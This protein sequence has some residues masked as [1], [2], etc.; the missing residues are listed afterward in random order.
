MNAS[1]RTDDELL[2]A[3]AENHDAL[4]FEELYTRHGG[5]VF[6]MCR[7]ILR[8]HEDAEDAAAACFLVLHRKAHSVRS[9]KLLAWLH[10]CAVQTA[11]RVYNTAKRRMERE[12]EAGTMEFTA[13]DASDGQWER[14][15]PDIEREIAA[16]S[17]VLREVLIMHFYQGLTRTEMAGRLQCAEGTIGSR[18]ANAMKTLRKRLTRAGADTTE[19]AISAGLMS[20]A[21]VVAMPSGLVMKL[22][23]ISQG[24][25]IGE[26]V[27]AMAEDTMRALMLAKMKLAAGIA[28]AVVCGVAVPAITISMALSKPHAVAGAVVPTSASAGKQVESVPI[29]KFHRRWTFDA[30]T[31]A[32]DFTLIQG[33]WHWERGADGEGCMVQDSKDGD[34]VFVL[35]CRVPR[36]PFVLTCVGRISSN[37]S[38]GASWIDGDKVL[39]YKRWKNRDPEP[40]VKRSLHTDR[41]FFIGRHIFSVSSAGDDVRGIAENQLEYPSDQIVVQ[42][43]DKPLR[44]LELRELEPEEVAKYQELLDKKL[45]E[46]K[47]KEV[48]FAD[49]PGE[50]VK[51]PTGAGRAEEKK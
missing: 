16:L 3:Y 7:R 8:I 50:K 6:S 35:P 22:A 43:I 31:L 38:L 46:L 21:L 51:I 12:Q 15:L 44:E 41:L 26:A 49:F 20:P 13:R 11:W 2:R 42:I 10:S 5:F 14:K 48:V 27:L 19:D 40:H 36:K 45:V 47:G 4:A 32:D 9:G 28:A 18:M 24:G 39:K 34:A 23:A 1:S 33:G 25:A 37:Q 30:K 17:P 29:G